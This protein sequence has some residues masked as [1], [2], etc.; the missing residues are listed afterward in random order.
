MNLH[1]HDKKIIPLRSD[2]RNF[3]NPNETTKELTLTLF[4]ESDNFKQVEMFLSNKDE[5]KD[6]DSKEYLSRSRYY[7]FDTGKGYDIDVIIIVL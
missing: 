7:K 1:P 5:N 2:Y 3:V 4:G 6:N